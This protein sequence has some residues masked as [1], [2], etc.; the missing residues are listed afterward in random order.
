MDPGQ[1]YYKFSLFSWVHS[2]LSNPHTWQLLPPSPIL[3]PRKNEGKREETAL[4]S[5]PL[6]ASESLPPFLSQKR[7]L[8][9]NPWLVLSLWC[10]FHS[11]LSLQEL[12]SFTYASPS[13]I[14]NF[15]LSPTFLS[16]HINLIN[17]PNLKKK[18]SN[19]NPAR[20]W[21]LHIFSC[22]QQASRE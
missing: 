14:F 10:G 1:S 21:L 19:F 7:G 9:S 8:P 15:S 4:V 22:P 5:S 6:Q 17:W 2:V 13:Q 3:L 20:Y 12:C 18:K 16:Q 11:L